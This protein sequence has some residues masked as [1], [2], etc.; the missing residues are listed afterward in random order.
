MFSFSD[1]LLVEEPEQGYVQASMDIIERSEGK[2]LNLDR[3]GLRVLP[4]YHGKLAEKQR[5]DL[6]YNNFS[7]LP[8][9]IG[10]LTQLKELKL[11]SNLC[12]PFCLSP[13]IG[14]LR[15]LV[16]LKLSG[17]SLTSLPKE[18]GEIT[19]MKMM[20][21][22]HNCL[23]ELPSSF[24]NLENL[25]ELRLDNNRLTKL[26][27]LSKS[28]N[29]LSLSFNSQFSSVPQV[30][31][32][33]GTLTKLNRIDLRACEVTEWPKFVEELPSLRELDL[34]CNRITS[35]PDRCLTR[36][37]CKETLKKLYLDH[38][39]LTEIPEDIGIL[40]FL[41]TLTFAGNDL[42]EIPLSFRHLTEL[43][44]FSID[45]DNMLIP[46]RDVVQKGLHEIHSFIV[47]LA[48][49]SFPC[50]RIRLLVLGDKGSG[51]TSLLRRLR[52]GKSLKKANSKGSAAVQSGE[53]YIGQRIINL[54][55]KREDGST[56]TV[57][58]NA[59]DFCGNQNTETSHSFFV[60]PKS[61]FIVTIDLRDV[62]KEKIRF[63]LQSI[64]TR[65][66]GASIFLIGTHADDKSFRDDRL[67][68]VLTSIAEEFTSRFSGIKVIMAV[69]SYD[70]SG[71]DA[72]R[73]SLV[74]E[75][76]E[77]KHVGKIVPKPYALLEQSVKQIASEKLEQQNPPLLSWEDYSAVG[78][79]CHIHTESSLRSATTYLRDL[80]VVITFSDETKVNVHMKPTL[81]LDP[82]WICKLIVSVFT[83]IILLN[84]LLEWREQ[85]RQQKWYCY[86]SGDESAAETPLVR[87]SKYDRVFRTIARIWSR[88]SRR[89]EIT[90]VHSNF[91][92]TP[93]A[94]FA[95]YLAL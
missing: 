4:P 28:L 50:Y 87:I 51:K 85:L 38:N 59:W 81:V 25:L 46:P 92:A 12:V 89:W 62:K 30:L 90:R 34:G 82:Q 40:R 79:T 9:E 54:T 76:L 68:S 58:F 91:V 39:Q 93:E 15:H 17:N 22:S 35:V 44:E 60:A 21:L 29:F 11:C 3:L 52:S 71:F 55:S 5:L 63:W 56:A 37:P 86:P 88:I 84:M 66:S 69:S 19:E 70:G 48:E 10:Q 74:R 64:S 83:V 45:E 14:N 18:I 57:E 77:E 24:E 6:S 2:T 26:P 80:G 53:Q 7:S 61:L 1:S 95:V 20:D 23:T 36:S 73:D 32:L 78:A 75:A 43:Q 33:I 67:S 8:S 94:K 16:N 72:L 42:H 49:E 65:A 31:A 47:S 13:E 41:R 27:K